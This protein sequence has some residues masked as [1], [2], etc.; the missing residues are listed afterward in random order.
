MA[1]LDQFDVRILRQ[2]Q[3]DAR[4]SNVKLASAVGLSPSPCLRR[5]RELI[6]RG[7]IRRQVALVDPDAAGLQ[8]TAF[9][10]VTLD[11]QGKEALEVFETALK[12]QPEV[13]ECYLMTG[14]ADYLVRVVT[15][16]LASYHRFL[17]DRL[18][19]I[20][21]IAN[22]K[23]SLALKQVQYRTALPLGHIGEDV[24]RR[25][26]ARASRPPVRPPQRTGGGTLRGTT[27][28]GRKDRRRATRGDLHASA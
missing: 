1:L 3:E 4:L 5:V 15:P 8:V 26:T 22:I 23:S 19:R 20:P 14:E 17:M 28:A 7:I 12:E 2:L 18:T 9:I 10:Q 25:V 27:T 11:K 24:H 21:G 6:R 16:D 13:M